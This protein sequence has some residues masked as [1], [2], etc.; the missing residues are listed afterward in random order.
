MR[1]PASQIK[2]GLLN[3]ICSVHGGS[4][5][6]CAPDS[7]EPAAKSVTETACRVSWFNIKMSAPKACCC[8]TKKSFDM[9]CQK[10]LDYLDQ[11]RLSIIF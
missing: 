9:K 7:S 8:F 11:E 5:D 10:P 2:T 3:R 1:S 4:Q 6:E